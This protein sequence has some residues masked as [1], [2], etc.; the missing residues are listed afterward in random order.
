MR[1]G[2]DTI[3]GVGSWSF[4]AWDRE[5]RVLPEERQGQPGGMG[6]SRQDGWEQITVG[7]VGGHGDCTV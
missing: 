6:T 7:L 2:K 5:S 1:P 4:Q 3:E